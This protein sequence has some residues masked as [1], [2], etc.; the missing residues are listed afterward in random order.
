[1]KNKNVRTNNNKNAEQEMKTNR[2]REIVR[3]I[4]NITNSVYTLEAI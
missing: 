3:S 2:E 4:F 1:M